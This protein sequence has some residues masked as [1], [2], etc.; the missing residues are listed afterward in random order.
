LSWFEF[1]D[2]LKIALFVML[3][4]MMAAGWY[5]GYGRQHFLANAKGKHGSRQALERV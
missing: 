2:L 5:H 3:D 4:R 1:V